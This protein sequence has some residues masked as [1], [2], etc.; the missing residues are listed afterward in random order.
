[1]EAACRKVSALG[2]TARHQ[3]DAKHSGSRISPHAPSGCQC[4]PCMRIACDSFGYL[5]TFACAFAGG[6]AGSRLD[7]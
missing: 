2:P 7:L 5:G 1:M 4:C 3:L 6:S